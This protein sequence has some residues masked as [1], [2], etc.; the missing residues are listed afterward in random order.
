MQQ[1]SPA[2]E[3]TPDT[4]K[5]SRQQASGAA[6][7]PL[8]RSGT[9][10][11]VV[12]GLV[13]FASL[14]MPLARTGL[15]DPPELETAELARRVAVNVFGAEEL[16]R[17][18]ADNS[19]PTVEEVGRGELPLLTL[20]LSL[21][22]FGSSVWALRLPLLLWAWLGL[23]AVYWVSRRLVSPKLGATAVVVLAT[24][25]L[26]FLHA[27]TAL[28]EIATMACS[29][30]AF[31]GLM[32]AAFDSRASVPARA[33]AYCVGGLAMVGGFFCRG[34]LIGV[35]LPSLC[36]SLTWLMVGRADA[37]TPRIPSRGAELLERATGLVTL[38]LG[39]GAAVWGGW[40]ALA[41][42]AGDYW[43]ALGSQVNEQKQFPTHDYIVHALGHG[44]FP[45]SAAAPLALG[46]ALYPS[47]AQRA[48]PEMAFRSALVLMCV[49]GVGLYTL[50][51]P[52]SGLIP[53]APVFAVALVIAIA[54]SDLDDNPAGFIRFGMVTAALLVLFFIDYEHFPDKAFSGYAIAKGS[55]PSSFE[56]EAK[57]FILVAAL[58]GAGTSALLVVL[59]AADGAELPSWVLRLR[60]ASTL[61]FLYDNAVW[62]GARSAAVGC[63]RGLRY[64]GA[65]LGGSIAAAGL[66][67]SL[68]YY[69]A[70][71]AQLSPTG[72]FEAYRELSRPGEELAQMGS[73]GGTTFFA[74][75]P[76]EVFTSTQKALDWLSENPES[77]RWLV[78][79]S[80]DLASL[81]YRFRGASPGAGNIPVLDSRSSRALLLSNLLRDG[82]RSQNPLDKWLP[83]ER[84]VFNHPLQVVLDKK[85]RVLGWEVR[86]A[87]DA[88]IADVLESGEP[89]EFRIGYEVLG[90]VSGTWKTF[91]HID[92]EGKRFNGDHD[93]LGGE[94]APRYWNKG[95]FV[96]D[97]H[98]FELEPSFTPGPYQVYFG[99]FSGDNRMPVSEGDHAENRI[100]GGIVQVVE[101]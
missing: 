21:K 100:N 40:A 87:R 17:D 58:L 56:R 35:A 91:I 65:V 75:E 2:T 97:V 15:W 28:G 3:I 59:R 26:F 63:G 64:R 83:A 60:R 46:Y 90:R 42:S 92:G 44:L 76:A 31:A 74:G 22:I 1:A 85:L 36:V 33:R 20:A 27:R 98:E 93:T 5:S 96:V 79:R 73:R 54:L 68:G 57:T 8:L 9:W 69:P 7:P 49:L 86:L 47:G 51:A 23:A 14:V 82:E 61:R 10:V 72:A 95:D 41:A 12:L 80:D 71:G 18:G 55:F 52:Q 38:I 32:I 19:V 50:L 70:L 67:L 101:P 4:E 30:L 43:V 48:R 81:N 34:A 89:Y 37:H 13:L 77:R 62:R 45:W 16:L 84:P 53:F 24:C 11:F 99:L 78:S 29:A 39:V 66:L 88:K 25:P 6:A 94:Y